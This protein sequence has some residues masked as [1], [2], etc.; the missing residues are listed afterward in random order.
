MKNLSFYLLAAALLGLPVSS[1]AQTAGPA[2]GAPPLT[3]PASKRHKG[4]H[5]QVKAM[6]E[7]MLDKLNLSPEVRA[8]IDAHDKAMAVDR[9]VLAK[10]EKG[11]KGSG[12]SEATKEKLKA[13]RKENGR[14]YKEVLTK[15]QRKEMKKLRVQARREAAAKDRQAPVKP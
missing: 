13:L 15:E 8:K 3:L 10:S 1:L 6:H 7:A 5:K 14:F 2:K 11:T 12:K 9:K 4:T